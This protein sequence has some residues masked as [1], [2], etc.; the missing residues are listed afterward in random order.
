[1]KDTE[2]DFDYYYENTLIELR[3][4]NPFIFCY[5]H[6]NP[7]TGK[8]VDNKE[9]YELYLRYLMLRDLY[10]VNEKAAAHLKGLLDEKN[11]AQ[12][13]IKNLELDIQKKDAETK[14]EEN[15]SFWMALLLSGSVSLAST[16]QSIQR[17]L[18]TFLFEFLGL[19]VLLFMFSS[20]VKEGF[21]AISSRKTKA[22]AGIGILLA[23]LVVFHPLM[24]RPIRYG[25]EADQRQLELVEWAFEYGYD[26]GQ[27]GH[28]ESARDAYVDLIGDIDDPESYYEIKEKQD[29]EEAE[30]AAN[31]ERAA[32]AEKAKE[33][34]HA[35]FVVNEKVKA[36]HSKDCTSVDMMKPENTTYWQGTEQELIEMGY[37]PHDCVPGGTEVQGGDETGP[38]EFT[39]ENGDPMDH[40]TEGEDSTS[41]GTPINRDFDLS[42]VDFQET[43][44]SSAFSKVGYIEED[45]VLVVVFRSTGP[46]KYDDVPYTVW[47]EFTNADSLGSYYNYHIKG[48]YPCEKIETE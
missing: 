25:E 14:K 3:K 20:L 35:S 31:A 17:G 11:E 5:G 30:A 45:E 6:E 40:Y 8:R 2:Y 21:G 24:D 1:M 29:E 34:A 16:L 27:D 22:A 41:R 13:T 39:I 7:F 36:Y 38:L 43:P 19:W 9:E 23:V 42:A 33:I 32:A 12:R 44:S 46:Y 26:A 47:E 10:E 15:A 48:E 4:N 18:L 28:G 37:H